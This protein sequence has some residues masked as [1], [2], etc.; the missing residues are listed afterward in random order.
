MDYPTCKFEWIIFIEGKG[1]I[2]FI[3]GG[4]KRW[5]LFIVFSS[6]WQR[7]PQFQSAVWRLV[8]TLLLRIYRLGF[9]FG[10]TSIEWSELLH[11]DGGWS[12][13][14]ECAA[15][16]FDCWQWRDIGSCDTVITHR[17]D[18]VSVRQG[19]ASVGSDRWNPTFTCSKRTLIFISSVWMCVSLQ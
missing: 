2:I 12:W 6:R 18:L 17:L 16:N 13:S 5:R 19:S 4:V 7:L 8:W 15:W 1:W 11:N 9:G 14:W 10:T 3:Y